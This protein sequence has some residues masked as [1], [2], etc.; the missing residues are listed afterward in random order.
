VSHDASRPAPERDDEHGEG[1]SHGS[2]FSSRIA[3]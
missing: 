3:G 2:G 1:R